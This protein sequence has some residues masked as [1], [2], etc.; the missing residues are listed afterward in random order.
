MTVDST[1]A[2]RRPLARFGVGL[3]CIGALS[4]VRAIHNGDQDGGGGGGSGDDFIIGTVRS[5]F[6]LR[7]PTSRDFQALRPR[8]HRSS[9]APFDPIV[10]FPTQLPVPG[11]TSI[12]YYSNQMSGTIPSQV[13]VY[14]R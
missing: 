8:S 3:A 4:S 6:A 7:H 12:S 13:R 14:S 11:T 1:R 9:T 10:Q 5:G 2:F